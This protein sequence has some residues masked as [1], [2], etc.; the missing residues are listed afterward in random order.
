MLDSSTLLIDT[1][2]ISRDRLSTGDNWSLY[3]S[4]EQYPAQVLGL[5]VGSGIYSGEMDAVDPADF[6]DQALQRIRA[7]PTCAHIGV[8]SEHP[9]YVYAIDAL[10]EKA[11]SDDQ[12][13]VARLGY[14]KHDSGLVTN[15]VAVAIPGSL[16][17]V[18]VDQ[19]SLSIE[20]L[21]RNV[22]RGKSVHLFKAGD[23]L[24]AVVNCHDYTH[25]KVLKTLYG[26][27]VD[28]I[29]VPTFN[30]A[31]RLYEE[32][33][34]SDIHRLF[35]VIVISNIANY[36]GSGVFAPFRRKGPK[37]GAV[38]LHGA[39]AVSRGPCEQQML[40][41]LPIK[42]LHAAKM[43]F[44]SKGS[45][46]LKKELQTCDGM[47]A[48]VPHEGVLLEKPHYREVIESKTAIERRVIANSCLASRKGDNLRV[49]VAHLQGLSV[50]KYLTSRYHISV[51]REYVEYIDR[52]VDQL[53]DDLRATNSGLDFL[54][55]P[56]VF[57]PLE[58][59]DKLN[60]FARE[61][62]A[63]VI[64]GIE[65]DKDDGDLPGENRC[66]ILIANTD[67]SISPHTYS[68]LTRSQYD[69]RRPA[70]A[71]NSKLGPEF[72][73]RLGNRLLIFDCDCVTFSVLICYDYSHLDLLYALNGCVSAT[74]SDILFVVAYNPDGELYRHC[75]LADS[76][77]FYQY[78]VMCNVAQFGGSGV[79]GPCKTPGERQTIMHA[80]VGVEGVSLASLD[81]MKLRHARTT[82]DHSIDALFM[83]KPGMYKMRT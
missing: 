24:I 19:Y 6:R 27:K 74:P 57:L 44:A 33:A 73:L 65:Y 9:G 60:A 32:Y 23:R 28:L 8:L 70:T 1:H 66:R 41:E 64:G 26:L 54:V 18:L 14:F 62:G 72:E 34:S 68:K 48:I 13:L 39:L 81:I 47:A 79:F 61:F 67:G 49:A 40:L 52:K 15:T 29:I 59:E 2:H 38:T 76:H 42:E 58:S 30:P 7:V 69:A 77:R 43:L 35:A 63:T 53:A 78:V 31:V 5:R 4:Q 21:S 51:Y 17:P 12:M 75:C 83:K 45:A 55:F 82:P 25:S 71:D 50:S 80:G 22:N 37:H 3:V 11:Q 10:V 36:G 46:D 16:K 56:E 20:D